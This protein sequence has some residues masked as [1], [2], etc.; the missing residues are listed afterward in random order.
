MIL[1]PLDRPLALFPKDLQL[2]PLKPH[3]LY[4]ENIKLKK[5]IKTL[6]NK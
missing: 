1:N 6:S 4:F 5:Q 3:G 2:V